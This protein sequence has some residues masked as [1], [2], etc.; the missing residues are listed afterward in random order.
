MYSSNSCV[1]SIENNARAICSNKS[2][3]ENVQF[4]TGSCIYPS[5]NSNVNEENFITLLD[6]HED[7]NQIELLSNYSHKDRALYSIDSSNDNSELIITCGQDVRSS[8]FVSSLWKFPERISKENDSYN[9][10]IL[11]L[12]EIAVFGDIENSIVS[13]AW[14][15]ND[16]LLASNSSVCMY[17]ITES[18]VKQISKLSVTDGLT[19]DSASNWSHGLCT[20]NPHSSSNEYLTAFNT[21]I[22]TVD[23]RTG[24]NNITGSI[25][26]AHCSTIRDINYNP[27]KPLTIISAG[28]DRNIKIWDL[29]NCTEPVKVV[30]DHSHW[31]WSAKY[32]P[33]HDQL[34]IR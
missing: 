13:I 7:Q 8:K 4:L 32:N 11:S 30:S 14:Q 31:I 5:S 2:A 29:R 25:K 23:A 16:V 6:Y 17:H 10:D 21:T 34:I 24:N 20:W 33:F 28:D 19:V 22:Q 1:Y 27:N 12:E 18:N 26:N 9:N 3:K 15:K